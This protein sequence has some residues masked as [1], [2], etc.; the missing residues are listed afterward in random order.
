MACS[1]TASVALLLNEPQLKM[2]YIYMYIENPTSY[3]QYGYEKITKHLNQ[4]LSTLQTSE[5]L[6][7]S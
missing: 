3:M 6:R 1:G 5:D 2:K 7:G 4:Q